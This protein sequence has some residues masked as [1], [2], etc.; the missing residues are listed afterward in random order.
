MSPQRP[1]PQ[2]L[3]LIDYQGIKSIV[4]KL[5]SKSYKVYG[6]TLG[7]S[8]IVYN[9]IMDADDLPRGY[10]DRQDG[11]TYRLEKTDDDTLFSCVVGPVSWKRF[12]YPPEQKLVRASS[13]VSGFEVEEVELDNAKIAFMGVRSCDLEA[14]RIQD[15]ILTEGQY[16]DRTYVAN[17]SNLVIIAVNCTR[18]GGTCFCDSM[19]AG[20]RARNGFDIAL[21]EVK[22]DGEWMYVAE[23]GT[24][25]G[26][27]NLKDIP[28]RNTD[29]DLEELVSSAMDKTVRQ[30]GRSLDT[31]DLPDILIGNFDHPH[32]EDVASRCLTCGN[33]TLVCPTCF[34][35]NIKDS[36]ALDGRTAVR[37]RKWDSCF[38]LDHSY[39]YGGSIRTSAAARYRQWITHKLGYWVDQF[40]MSGCVGCGRCITWCPVGIDITR[41]AAAIRQSSRVNVTESDEAVVNGES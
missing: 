30:M 37:L 20:P 2:S 18:A 16:T 21:T 13:T 15:K 14:I 11:G 32:W 12:L 7:E 5:V 34:C 24:K 17:R 23:I 8:A 6:P 25:T 27:D 31:T 3:L 9:Q 4:E 41:E 10:I 29:M 28:D 19:G 26:K 1:K 35:I 38:T 39:I 40:G 36:T 22:I 33:C